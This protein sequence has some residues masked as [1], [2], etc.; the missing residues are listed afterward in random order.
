MRKRPSAREPDLELSGTL[1][2]GLKRALKGEP[3]IAS[4]RRRLLVLGYIET[5][6]EW[7]RLTPAGLTA[8]RDTP[9][10]LLE[11]REG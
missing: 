8:L 1:R 6:A 7:S 2:Q 10:R 9:A 4:V 11:R 5:A 3:L